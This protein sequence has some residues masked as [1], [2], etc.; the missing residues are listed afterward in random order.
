MKVIYTFKTPEKDIFK[1]ALQRKIT[2]NKVPCF[3][4]CKPCGKKGP[5]ILLEEKQTPKEMLTT[6][7]HEVAHAF[8]YEEKE[9][10]VEKF[11]K[12]CVSLFKKVGFKT[13]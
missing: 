11:A 2:K 13:I 7:I 3:G 4:I 5:V 10:V 9:R 1:V 8:F 6:I 12:T